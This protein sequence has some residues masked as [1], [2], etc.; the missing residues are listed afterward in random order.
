MNPSLPRR[1]MT[2]R[3]RLLAP[4]YE[5]SGSCVRY[6]TAGTPFFQHAGGSFPITEDR[7]VDVVD[8][9]RNDHPL[10]ITHLSAPFIS[11]VYGDSGHP[12]GSAGYR[13][14]RDYICQLYRGFP[15]P[16]HLAY[17]IPSEAADATTLKARTN[18]SRPYVNVPLIIGE[19]KDLP[20]LLK[21]LGH[22]L[23]KSKKTIK[24]FHNHVGD[25]FMSGIYGIAPMISDGLK[26]TDFQKRVQK[27]TNEL[28]RLYSNGGLRRRVTLHKVVTKGAKSTVTVEGQLATL[29]AVRQDVMVVERWGTIRWLPDE[30]PPSRP[31][32][33]KYAQQ[34]QDVLLGLGRHWSSGRLARNDGWSDM[35]DLWNLMPWSWMV[36]WFSNAG[37]FIDSKRNTIPASSSRINIMTKTTTTRSYIRH[38]GIDSFGYFNGGGASF[39]R[40]TKVRSQQNGT[41]LA[42][43]F[44][45][46]SGSQMSILGALA[47]QRLRVR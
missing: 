39:V 21:Y 41:A 4:Q 24:N 31:S 28:E 11:P 42:A 12:A 35:S 30:L 45:F 37:D 1:R 19:M 33:D 26:M 25:A 34:A 44:P 15:T 2:S 32:E 16:S 23:I 17:S 40:E 18:P 47:M 13:F 20:G 46:L 29:K 10:T 8:G 9:T 7:C 22:D 36:D 3:N 43:S 6:V 14:A 5:E 38:Q 27:R